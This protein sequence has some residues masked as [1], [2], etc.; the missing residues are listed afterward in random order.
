MHSRALLNVPCHS[1]EDVDCEDRD[2]WQSQRKLGNGIVIS[3]A[4]RLPKILSTAAMIFVNEVNS[5]VGSLT[6]YEVMIQVAV[7]EK[8]VV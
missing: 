4:K 8:L 7:Y 2:L 1:L 5:S 3:Q 6:K